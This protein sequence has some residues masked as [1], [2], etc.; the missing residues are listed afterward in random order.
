MKEID[1]GLCGR[2]GIDGEWGS[3]LLGEVRITLKYCL[4]EYGFSLG[5]IKFFLLDWKSF[6]L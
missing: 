5:R 6:T 2:G 3:G 1:D 4:S